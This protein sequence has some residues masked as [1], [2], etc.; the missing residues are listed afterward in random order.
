MLALRRE[1]G[2]IAQHRDEV[3]FPAAACS[4]ARLERPRPSPALTMLAHH[5][6]PEPALV[7]RTAHLDQLVRRGGL[8]FERLQALLKLSSS[9]PARPCSLAR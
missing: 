9:G 8:T 1:S 6:N 4:A 2:A 3:F 5:S 7:R